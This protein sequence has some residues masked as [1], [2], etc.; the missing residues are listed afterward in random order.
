[1]EFDET[2]RVWYPRVARDAWIDFSSQIV[3]LRPSE[4]RENLFFFSLPFLSLSLCL[5]PHCPIFPLLVFL[6]F[7][8][9]SLLFLFS[10]GLI[11]SHRIVSF[12]FVCSLLI[13]LIFSFSHFPS[14]SLLFLF[15]HFLFSFS[16]LNCINRMVPKV[17]NFL[18]TSSF[19]SCHSPIFLN[20]FSFPFIFLM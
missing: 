4:H 17:G 11:L 8:P 15:L 9:F 1:M 7:P 2:Q 12:L 5:L 19:G 6:S 20:L 13:F 10:F 18:P 14:F 16:P 3:E